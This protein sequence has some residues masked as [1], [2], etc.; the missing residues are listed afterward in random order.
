MARLY[1]LGHPEE[2]PCQTNRV[3][4]VV[5][6]EPPA[7]PH[8]TTTRAWRR[9]FGRALTTISTSLPRSTRKRTSRS[10]E[11]PASRPRVSAEAL[12]EHWHRCYNDA[13]CWCQR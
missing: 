11:N 7:M 12:S 1:R 13:P 8:A 6:I 2:S 5:R 3:T 9:D 10:S 4:V